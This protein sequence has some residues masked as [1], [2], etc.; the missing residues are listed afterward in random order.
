[1][2][3]SRAAIALKAIPERYRGVLA[4]TYQPIPKNKL[5]K[6]VGIATLIGAEKSFQPQ[7]TK[8]MAAANRRNMPKKSNACR[9]RSE[10]SVR[11][12]RSPKGIEGCGVAELSAGEAEGK[13]AAEA[14]APRGSSVREMLTCWLTGSPVC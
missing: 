11:H 8:E 3:M 2:G 1:M 12:R 14:W 13:E 6:R 4:R 7:I 9:V 5:V 10:R